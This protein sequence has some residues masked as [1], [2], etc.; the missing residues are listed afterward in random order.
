MKKLENDILAVLEMS[1]GLKTREIANK[2]NTDYNLVNKVLH[3]TLNSRCFQNLS[4]QWYIKGINK[5]I[6]ANE[7]LDK[8][9]FDLCKYY[10]NCLSLEENNG[11]SAFLKSKDNLNYAELNSIKYDETNVLACQIM[12]KVASDRNLTAYIGYPVMI[13]QTYSAK[14]KNLKL[15]PIFL[16]AVDSDGGTFKTESIPNVNIEAIKQYSA[17]DRDNR[18]YELID[19]ET[20]LG[21][22]NSNADIEINEL[23]A[24]LQSIRQWQWK[25]TLDPACIDISTAIEA[26]NEEGIYNRAILIVA[27]KSPFTVGLESELSKLMM[28]DKNTY[29]DT[30][31]YEWIHH[32]TSN[33]YQV[34]DD[35]NILEVAPLNI[36]QEQAIRR[37][38]TEN[39]TVITGPPGTGK[40]QVV[41]NLLVNIAWR[42]ENVLFSSK[43]NKAVDVVDKRVNR[44][45]N[46]PVMLRIGG[47]QYATPFAELI[48]DLLNYTA[49]QNDYEE[50]KDYIKTYR[51][52]ILIYQK[53]KKEKEEI[54][55]LRN[56][57]DRLEQ[58]IC[59]HRKKWN[60][61]IG[62][63]SK[64]DVV[65][66]N[67]AYEKCISGYNYA[68]KSKQ[69]FFIKLFWF[70]FGKSRIQNANENIGLLNTYLSQYDIEKLPATFSLL[71]YEDF[72]KQ[73]KEIQYIIGVF[74]NIVKYTLALKKLSS[75]ISLEDI[76]R[77]LLTQKEVLSNTSK[78][79]WNKW[80]LIQPMNINDV[81]RKNMYQYVTAMKL[82]DDV[83]LEK[84]PEMQKQFKQLQQYMTQFLP[85]WAVTSLSVKARIPFQ[86]GMFDLLIIDEASQCDIASAIPLLYRAKKAVIIGDPKQLNHISN[87]SK[88]QDY[89]LLR[90][91]GINFEWCY[92][93]NSLYTLASSLAKLSEIVQL[94]DHHRS[95]GAI[96]EFSNQEFYNGKLRVATNYDQLIYPDENS[97]GIK[98]IDV[99]GQTTRPSSGSAYN[100]MEIKTI[101]NE[102]E[103]LI[104]NNDYKGSIGI[105][106]PFKAQADRIRSTIEKNEKMKIYLHLHNNFLVDT[107]HKFQGDERDVMIFSTV[108]SDGTVSSTIKFLKN[109]GNLFNVG[110]TRA[111]AL[112]IVVGNMEYCAES[113]IPYLEHFVEYVQKYTA[114]TKAEDNNLLKLSSR[115]YPKV[116]NPEQV[117][118]WEK[119]LYSA[120][121]DAKIFTTPQYPADKYRLDLALIIKDHKLDIEIDGEMYHKDWN[122]EVCYRDQ[123]RN[124][125]LIEIGWEI[126][127][128]W[129]Y[130]IRDNLEW[131]VKQVQDWKN[132]I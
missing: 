106:T 53:I 47:S 43:N 13:T 128:F 72:N 125:R 19:L 76:D 27:E 21:L 29:K 103:N 93:E 14:Q 56:Q 100:D 10:L 6:Q 39:L 8:K 2:L 60:N 64:K 99:A 17:N 95:N 75:A 90:K 23:V 85:C 86:P 4:Y 48:S 88:S 62:K 31:L 18:I 33:N 28:I 96:I 111:K 97:T 78:K 123:L 132:N 83:D 36:E 122:G 35:E 44:L 79:L 65:E 102:L 34:A 119:I 58:K 77:Q 63:I 89:N 71:N 108:I 80:L 16:F 59:S 30:A 38:L 114:Q 45:G 110:I 67:F 3:D 113:G 5:N 25:E 117:S 37:S 52:E 15:V 81:Y 104:I 66:L 118:D 107:V 91:Y 87:I 84:Y 73:C 92:S 126:K 55:S 26:I 54:I 127:R 57:V 120:L 41:T 50:Y 12:Q 98:W 116:S 40:S 20:E 11:I 22:N 131:C 9:L 112:L 129:V 74:N 121:F 124:Q 32:K 82:I 105:V 46:R 24:R 70:I 61:L 49:D 1:P 94:K 7:N 130:Q 68:V 51:D 115:E 42:G 69:S 101:I 109:T